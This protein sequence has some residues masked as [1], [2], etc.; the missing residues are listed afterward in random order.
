M[1]NIKKG[2]TLIIYINYIMAHIIYLTCSQPIKSHGG[3]I[4]A[5]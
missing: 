3:K 1:R 5:L 2:L 4:G